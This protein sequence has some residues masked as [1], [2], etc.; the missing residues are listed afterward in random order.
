MG[1]FMT[2]HVRLQRM[3]ENQRERL[4]EGMKDDKRDFMVEHWNV[5]DAI[6]YQLYLT[7]R[8]FR[9][10]TLSFG[11]ASTMAYSSPTPTI[12][13][14]RPAPKVIVQAV[15]KSVQVDVLTSMPCTTSL[16]PSYSPPLQAL[17]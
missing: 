1:T 2:Q 4:C 11:S 15:K 8:H 10:A 5:L 17:S 9:S 3:L 12:P 7:T 16:S 13:I 6:D 14:V